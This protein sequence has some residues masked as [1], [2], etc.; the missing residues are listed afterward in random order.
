MTLLDAATR[1]GLTDLVHGFYADVRADARLGP[2]FDRAIGDHW[3]AHLARMVEFWSTV[4][5][6]TRS[7]KGDVFGKHMAV[8]GVQPE[9][10]DIWLRLWSQHTER[11]FAP[12][13]ARELQNLAGGVA[14]NLFRGYFG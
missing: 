10:F 1:E 7:F 2:L 4:T 6:G 9:H 13:V 8:D 5:L 12:E 3:D 11:V 14:R